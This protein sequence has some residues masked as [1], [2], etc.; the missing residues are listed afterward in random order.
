MKKELHL[1]LDVHKDTVAVGILRPGAVEPDHREPA[2]LLTVRA[3]SIE[4]LSIH[5]AVVGAAILV[6]IG[7]LELLQLVENVTWGPAGVELIEHVPL[8]PLVMIGGV[9]V[10]LAVDR[11]DRRSIID[12][13][14]MLRVQ[15]LALDALILTALATIALDVIGEHLVPFALLAA[16]G[17][18]WN[19]LVFVVFARR[20]IPEFWFERGI[21]GFRIDVAHS[22][23]EDPEF[24]DNPLIR[25]VPGVRET[26]RILG[27]ASFIA[28]LGGIASFKGE[29]V[30][31]N[32]AFSGSGSPFEAMARSGAAA[33]L[34]EAFAGRFEPHAPW[35][36]LDR[37]VSMLFRGHVSLTEARG[38]LDGAGFDWLSL[39]DNGIIPRKLP[40]SDADRFPGL[41][42][43]EVHAYHLVPGG[44]SK[45]KGVAFHMR[46]RG[47]APEETIAAMKSYLQPTHRAAWNVALS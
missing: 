5:V 22:L 20:I 13:G 40:R 35:A 3:S 18:A 45:A 44:A 46:A 11:F 17:I 2:A 47:Y 23:L 25:D 27:S 38:L 12:R 24:R 43:D 39:E 32:G 8:F 42:V 14:M 6:G 31:D 16:A 9:I 19:I 28:E 37:E 30:Q 26:A 7:L 10:Q 36:H 21:D 34:M 4:P 29:I 33:L 41:E 1:G 15:G